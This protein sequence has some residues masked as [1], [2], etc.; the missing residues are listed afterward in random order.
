[1][2]ADTIRPR[3]KEDAVGSAEQSKANRP[4]T[5]TSMLPSAATIGFRM[6]GTATVSKQTSCCNK[7]SN[8]LHNNSPYGKKLSLKHQSLFAVRT[9]TGNNDV[10]FNVPTQKI[11]Q[12]PQAFLWSGFQ[13]QA[14]QL[15]GQ[16]LCA[17]HC[18]AAGFP[19][20]VA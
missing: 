19:Q 3:R 15:P 11:E 1:M 20:N 6:L 14:N 8:L 5:S 9:P 16:S 13:Q 10:S 12:Y 7:Q 2:R 4:T 18:H 17:H